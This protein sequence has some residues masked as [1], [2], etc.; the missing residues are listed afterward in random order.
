[1]TK[2]IVLDF[3]MIKKSNIDFLI[4]LTILKAQRYL[5]ELLAGYIPIFI[6]LYFDL[7]D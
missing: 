4:D 3:L 2:C 1:M 7:A 6:Y 5:I